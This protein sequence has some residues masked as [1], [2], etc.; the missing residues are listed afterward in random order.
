MAAADVFH[1]VDHSVA[2]VIFRFDV[3]VSVLPALLQ[4]FD[5]SPTA[6]A[7]S[8]GALP[9][10][11]RLVAPNIAQATDT[12]AEVDVNSAVVDQNRVHLG[13]G[14]LAALLV[15]EFNEGILQAVSRFLVPDHLAA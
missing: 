7:S 5:A 11:V 13:V 2:S 4:L 15:L 1:P 9:L 6:T 3:L 8:G 14:I 10:C 12:L